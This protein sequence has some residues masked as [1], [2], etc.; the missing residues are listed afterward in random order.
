MNKREFNIVLKVVFKT[1]FVLFSISHYSRVI[2]MTIFRTAKTQINRIVSFLLISLIISSG[3]VSSVQAAIVS[4]QD[5]AS[6]S[7]KLQA[8]DNVRLALQRIDVQQQLSSMGVEASVVLSRVDSMTNTEIQELSGL[9]EQKPAGSGI[10]GLLGFILVVLL[11]TD[12]LKLTNV[13]NL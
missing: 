9:I 13:Y 2:M 12:L 3:F 8:R 7:L 10:I 6:V 11:I 5:L 4:S 1:V